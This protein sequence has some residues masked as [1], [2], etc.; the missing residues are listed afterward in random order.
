MQKVSIKN[1]AHIEGVRTIT[2]FEAWRVH[3]G[4]VEYQD[5]YAENQDEYK[6]DDLFGVK[7]KLKYYDEIEECLD[8]CI[9]RC[10]EVC[11]HSEVYW[12][13]RSNPIYCSI[14]GWLHGGVTEAGD[15][16]SILASNFHEL[17]D[18]QPLFFR[19]PFVHR[20]DFT[21]SEIIFHSIENLLDSGLRRK[22]SY[23]IKLIKRVLKDTNY[24]FLIERF[25]KK[26][27]F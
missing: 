7:H 1:E 2:Y 6:Y 19:E 20:I 22:D 25:E 11:Y 3:D 23:D 27:Y 21:N 17:D 8:N 12:V 9:G 4:V 15:L 5:E 16:K 24:S 18:I 26:Y 10:C 14:D 13:D